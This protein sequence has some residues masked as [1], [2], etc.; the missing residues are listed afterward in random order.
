MKAC[1]STR[2]NQCRTVH[3]AE[4]SVSSTKKCAP[5]SVLRKLHACEQ[6]PRLLSLRSSLMRMIR[7]LS[8]VDQMMMQT[9]RPTSLS[10]SETPPCWRQFPDFVSSRSSV[11]HAF[12]YHAMTHKH[13]NLKVGKAQREGG[14][15]GGGQLP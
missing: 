3:V 8:V 15:G 13:V 10:L 6:Q 2:L 4:E 11:S 12:F 1:T 5:S 9:H 7:L 14:W